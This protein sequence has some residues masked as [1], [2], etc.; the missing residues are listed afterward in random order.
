MV[1]VLCATGCILLIPKILSPPLPW[2]KVCPQPLA[3]SVWRI[4]LDAVRVFAPESSNQ[5]TLVGFLIKI[6]EGFA[7]GIG[8]GLGFALATW[9]LGHF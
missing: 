7:L 6:I 3:S 8:G 5:M 9:L 4:M 2:G 1:E